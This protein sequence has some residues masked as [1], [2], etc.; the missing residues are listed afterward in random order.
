[1]TTGVIDYPACM[2]SACPQCHGA[3]HF[4]EAG[5]LFKMHCMNCDWREAGTVSYTWPEMPR[6]ERMPAMAVKAGAPVP[7]ATLKCVRDTFV[8]ARR[9]SL[10]QLAEQFSSEDGLMVGTLAPY[11]MSEV[12]A[13]LASTG[14]RLE[15]VPH[16]DDDRQE[17]EASLRSA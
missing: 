8:E 6:A 15:R 13:R 3:V 16:E 12:M 14:A 10:S 11:R 5:G 1:M 7:A 9:L 4:N 17:S 2:R